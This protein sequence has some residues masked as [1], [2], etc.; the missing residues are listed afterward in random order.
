MVGVGLDGEVARKVC[1]SRRGTFRQRHYCLPTMATLL[2]YKF[3]RASLTI[4]GEKITDDATFIQVANTWKY[5]GPMVLV[6]QADRSDGMLD[7][8]LVEK[9]SRLRYLWY[10]M[11]S[12]ILKRVK[13]R[14]VRYFKG[15][16]VLI[17]SDSDVPCQVD[18][19]YCGSLP[20][21]IEIVPDSV[22]IVVNP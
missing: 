4:D 1:N 16:R 6:P 15:R 20:M 7:V 5:G 8:L 13:D 2:G 17:E 19:D 11:Q 14:G 10:L 12:A 18:G 3:H 9:C 21:E 22:R